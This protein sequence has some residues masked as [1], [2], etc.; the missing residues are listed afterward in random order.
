METE[1][2]QTDVVGINQIC[3]NYAKALTL[4]YVI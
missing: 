4:R 1:D 3:I 2:M